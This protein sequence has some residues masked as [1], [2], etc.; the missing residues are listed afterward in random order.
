MYFVF[1]CNGGMGNALF[2]YLACCVLCI[3]FNGQYLTTFTP[4]PTN[5]IEEIDEDKFCQIF[6]NNLQLTPGKY[7]MLTKCYVHDMIFHNY[8][9]EIK[10]FIL[11][12]NHF[13]FIPN[14]DTD[15]IRPKREIISIKKLFTFPNDIPEYDLVIHVKLGN[16]TKNG[17]SIPIN[18]KIKAL[19]KLS[20]D[21]TSINSVAIVTDSL[22][23]EYEKAYVEKIKELLG[24]LYN[25]ECE[26]QSNDKFTD[27]YIMANAEILFCSISRLSWCAAFFSGRINTC[28]MP[29]S[30]YRDINCTF[31]YPISN[32]Y[33][34]D[35]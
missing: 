27:F 35:N 21:I 11:K 20:K 2:R 32:T 10:S 33:F 19:N 4:I 24:K 34:Y 18:K 22:N 5:L 23:T 13:I 28:Y 15:L 8:K 26:V 7:Y 1:N 16:A 9:E 29:K 30:E 25:I 12:N 17:Y 3:K 6:Q 31:C 14:V